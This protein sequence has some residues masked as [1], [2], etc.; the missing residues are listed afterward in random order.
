MMAAPAAARP[1][2]AVLLRSAL[3][4][5]SATLGPIPFQILDCADL[6]GRDAGLVP[7]L[8]VGWRELL[9][10]WSAVHQRRGRSAAVALLPA[11]A[12]AQIRLGPD[13]PDRLIMRGVPVL[14][15]GRGRCPGRLVPSLATTTTTATSPGREIVVDLEGS[16]GVCVDVVSMVIKATPADGLLLLRG[17]CLHRGFA[18]RGRRVLLLLLVF[19][20]EE[21]ILVRLLSGFILRFARL[22]GS[23]PSRE[24]RRGTN[25]IHVS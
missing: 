21:L 2:F 19:G 6:D 23:W 24:K 3:V 22:V 12:P 13:A 14:L 1:G 18:W 5:A 15:A 9:K 11:N 17:A 4:V 25:V 20:A 7:V 8:V 10:G 16:L